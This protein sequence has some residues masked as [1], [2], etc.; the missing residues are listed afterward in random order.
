MKAIATDHMRKLAEVFTELSE[1]TREGFHEPDEQGIKLVAVIGTTLDNAFGSHI[2]VDQLTAGHQEAVVVFERRVGNARKTY[3]MNLAD[4]CALAKIGASQLLRYTIEETS[5]G[6]AQHERR[7]EIVV[8]Y[9]HVDGENGHVLSP[10]EHMNVYSLAN[11]FGDLA[12]G[13]LRQIDGG[14][15][16]SHVRDSDE[17]GVQRMYDELC[18]ILEAKGIEIPE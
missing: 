3:Q 8:S 15:D 6:D 13:Q 16:W 11:G 17:F 9:M 2:A 18:R 14:Y 4:L 10:T 7:R 1:G 5:I 12:P